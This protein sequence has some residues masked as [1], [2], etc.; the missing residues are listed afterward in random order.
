MASPAP[1]PVLQEPPINRLFRLM[2]QTGATDLHLSVS[3]PPMVRKDGRMLPVEE[4]APRLTAEDIRRL[5][6]PITPE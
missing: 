4:T 1:A 6:G 5:L 2:V 3:E